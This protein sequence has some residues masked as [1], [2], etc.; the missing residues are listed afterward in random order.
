MFLS[1]GEADFLQGGNGSDL[2]EIADVTS[3][4]I[5]IDNYSTKPDQDFVLLWRDVTGNPDDYFFRVDENSDFSDGAFLV[6]C[7]LTKL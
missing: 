1:Q 6:L 7:I 4:S 2:C 5:F 3:G